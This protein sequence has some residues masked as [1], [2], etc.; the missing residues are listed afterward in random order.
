MTLA[1]VDGDRPV[2][3]Q[4]SGALRRLIG[5]VGVNEVRERL[6][7]ELFVC[8]TECLFPGRIEAGEVTV[9]RR[10]AEQVVGQGEETVV[11]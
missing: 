5:V 6:G 3:D 8:P 4:H 10:R 2:D 7:H 9:E 1:L 11:A